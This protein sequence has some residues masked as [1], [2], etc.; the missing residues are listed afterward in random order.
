M[1]R[2][3]L[4]TVTLGLLACVGCGSS[5]DDDGATG[6]GGSATGGSSSGG[7]GNASSGGASG[8]GG[9]ATGGSSGSGGQSPCGSP[10]GPSDTPRIDCVSGAL[11]DGSAIT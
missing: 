5:G 3:F 9:S 1:K 4:S 11:I 2:F 10:G 8:N 7:T 6:S